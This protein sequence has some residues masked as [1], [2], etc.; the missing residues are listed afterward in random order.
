MSREPM[1]FRTP[2]RRCER[3]RFSPGRP[4]GRPRC[5]PPLTPVPRRR[6]LLRAVLGQAAG[7]GCSCLARPGD[8]SP[9]CG[10]RV[11]TIV[12]VPKPARSSRPQRRERSRP[13]RAPRDF[14][15]ASQQ[16]DCGGRHPADAFGRP[17]E[18]L[19]E[20]PGRTWRIGT[21][22]RQGM[23]RRW[24]GGR[25]P[26]LSQSPAGSATSADYAERWSA[27]DPTLSA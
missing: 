18:A 15:F 10:H 26:S 25:D 21:R 12:L 5:P 4:S 8:R 23:R 2:F 13:R 17:A 16:R 11:P 14:S 24:D 1:P 20:P 9:R 3:D 7:A 22:P 6:C 19:R 27:R